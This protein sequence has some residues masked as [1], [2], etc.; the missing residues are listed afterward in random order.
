MGEPK[1]GSLHVSSGW[2]LFRLPAERTETNQFLMASVT[3]YEAGG[4]LLIRGYGLHHM[5]LHFLT[6]IV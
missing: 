6:G 3:Q 2:T 4:V 1:E 5:S